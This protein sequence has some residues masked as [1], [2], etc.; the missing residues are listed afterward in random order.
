MFTG[1]GRHCLDV[2]ADALQQRVG[3]GEA[4]L[5]LVVPVLVGLEAAD[6]LDFCLSQ[7]IICGGVDGYFP[8]GCYFIRA[9][10]T[11]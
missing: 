1:L 6:G 4:G 8:P 3:V 7:G 9:C 11:R 5:G 2:L 10:L